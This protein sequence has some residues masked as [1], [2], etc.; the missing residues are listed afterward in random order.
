MVVRVIWEYGFDVPMKTPGLYHVSKLSNLNYL[1]KIL[2]NLSKFVKKL[3]KKRFSPIYGLKVAV[4][5]FFPLIPP[6]CDI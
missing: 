4:L 6:M 2:L 5:A 3:N 1:F